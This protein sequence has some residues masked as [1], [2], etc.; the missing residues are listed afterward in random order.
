MADTILRHGTRPD[1]ATHPCRAV[2]AEEIAHYQELGWVKLEAF[3]HLDIVE[4]LLKLGIEKLGEDGDSNP[5][6]PILQDLFNHACAGALHDP[7]LRPLL[8]GIGKNAKALMQRQPHVEVRYF[9][10]NYAV[11]LPAAKPSRHGGNGRTHFHHD[12]PNWQLDRSGGMAFWIAL[13]DMGPEMGTMSFVNGSQRLGVLGNYRNGDLLEI[14]PEIL[15]RCSLSAPMTYEAGDV[16][17]HSNLTVHG[18]GFNRTQ[19][20]RWAYTVLVNPAD[21]RWN[22][23]PAEAYD[24]T[25]MTVHQELDDERF[26]I[27]SR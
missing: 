2:T 8:N 10:E 11:K 13:T 22:G 5:P 25:H 7:M 6:L 24:T 14:Y 26:P 16:T 21:A 12:F 27:L 15:E 3:V 17:V 18:A 23:A 20:P 9:T 4:Y 1:A 19:Q